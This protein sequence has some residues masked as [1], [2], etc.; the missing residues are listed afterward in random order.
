MKTG[1]GMNWH[2]DNLIEGREY[3][4]RL[5]HGTVRG[6]FLGL[7]ISRSRRLGIKMFAEFGGGRVVAHFRVDRIVGCVELRGTS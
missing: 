4:L 1:D 2:P 3:L 7:A 5:D 6:A